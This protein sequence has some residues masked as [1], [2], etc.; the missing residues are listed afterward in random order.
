MRISCSAVGASVGARPSGQYLALV[1]S[2]QL[3]LSPV[4][5]LPSLRSGS[6]TEIQRV[7]RLLRTIHFQ[8]VK[9]WQAAQQ[10]VGLPQVF[11]MIAP[12][13]YA[14]LRLLVALFYPF[15]IVTTNRVRSLFEVLRVGGSEGKQIRDYE[16]AKSPIMG[17]LYAAANGRII[18]AMICSGGIQAN[19]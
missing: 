6:C 15:I 2:D 5:A 16:S 14:Q 3:L 18:L 10:R 11:T 8:V 7:R 19:E 17:K 4:L 1:A 9:I 12:T 13:G